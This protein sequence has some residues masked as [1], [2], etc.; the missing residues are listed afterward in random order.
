MTAVRNGDSSAALDYD[1]YQVDEEVTF[2]VTF[3]K[4]NCTKMNCTT[5][6]CKYLCWASASMRTISFFLLCTHAVENSISVAPG[7]YIDG[8]TAVLS[9]T[10]GRCIAEDP[11]D[12]EL[13]YI[14]DPPD[15][16]GYPESP[17]LFSKAVTDLT[18]VETRIELSGLKENTQYQYNISLVR[19]S[20]GAT[21]GVGVSGEFIVGGKLLSTSLVL[22]PSH[23]VKRWRSKLASW[24]AL[25]NW[26]HFYNRIYLV[27]VKELYMYMSCGNSPV[28]YFQVCAIAMKKPPLMLQWGLLLALHL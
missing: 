2:C 14:Y 26:Q 3:I 23:A 6:K 17:V 4:D 10:Y 25:L 20:D 5:E 11:E 18:G 13:R 28:V 15:G 9:V 24:S 16:T 19:R 8:T 1:E 7:V 12:L 27:V 21:I 22:R